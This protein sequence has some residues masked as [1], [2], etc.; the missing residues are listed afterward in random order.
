ML[1]I[2]QQVGGSVGIAVLSLTLHRRA[3]Y[4]LGMVGAAASSSSPAYKNAF[5]Q[6]MAR[7]HEIGYSHAESLRVAA[8]TVGRHIAEAASVR[9]FQDSFLVGAC[10]VVISLI[11]VFKLPSKP[12]V[13]ASAEPVHLE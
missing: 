6:V 10:I 13:H 12:M 8:M 7:A 5:G 3:A 4:H 11:G 2:I 9:A 1:N